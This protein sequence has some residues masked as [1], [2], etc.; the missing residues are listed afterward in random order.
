MTVCVAQSLLFSVAFGK[1]LFV[2]LLFFYRPL[3][4][5]PFLEL[6]LLISDYPYVY[7]IFKLLFVTF[8]QLQSSN[9]MQASNMC[10]VRCN[11]VEI[12]VRKCWATRIP[13]NMG[14]TVFDAGG[15]AISSNYKSDIH[16]V[17]KVVQRC[18]TCRLRCTLFIT[19]CWYIG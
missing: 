9:L 1:L 5:L 16:V 18:F 7:G 3:S 19:T 13:Q 15:A 2:F 4:C 8:W 6:R 12:E 11:I 10:F 17:Q 14:T